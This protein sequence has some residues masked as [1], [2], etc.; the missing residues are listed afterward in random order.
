M[1]WESFAQTFGALAQAGN[2]RRALDIDEA[3][4]AAEIAD[5]L[6]RDK[7]VRE[8]LE[9]RERELTQRAQQ[10]EAALDLQR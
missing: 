3:K 1:G 4:L 2:A 10:A 6:R 8:E 9:L 5:S 7:R